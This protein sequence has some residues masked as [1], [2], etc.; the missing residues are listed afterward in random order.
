MRFSVRKLLLLVTVACLL[1]GVVTMLKLEFEASHQ[2]VERT[3]ELLFAVLDQV[4]GVPA[5]FSILSRGNNEDAVLDYQIHRQLYQGHTISLEIDS[6]GAQMS[7]TELRSR[8][9]DYYVKELG[10]RFRGIYSS[11]ELPLPGGQQLSTAA[12][13]N[14]NGDILFVE[15]AADPA[16][17]Q[18]VVRVLVFVADN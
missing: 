10:R 11:V 12:L 2:R 17:R 15:A 3:N 16:E 13:S 4:G 6:T 8:L 14:E 7:S 9:I 18:A 5:H 1:V